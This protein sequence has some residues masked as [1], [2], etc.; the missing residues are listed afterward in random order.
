MTAHLQASIGSI[1][2]A[3]SQLR[4]RIIS[5]YQRAQR[6]IAVASTSPSAKTHA[7]M[8]AY[9]KACEHLRADIAQA[10]KLFPS[11]DALVTWVLEGCDARARSHRIGP[12]R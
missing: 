9:D 2:S 6:I 12:C 5:T 11:T 3:K 10:G 8:I 7:L 1:G 4:H